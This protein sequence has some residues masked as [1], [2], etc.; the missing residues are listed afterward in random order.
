MPGLF[1]GTSL[2]RPVTCERCLKPLEACACPRNAAGEIALPADQSPRVR[3]ERRRGAWTTVITGLDP[4]ATDL[5]SLCA[6]LKRQ[7]AS[8]GS[9]KKDA[10]EIQGDHRD[11]V[12]ASLKGLGYAAKAAGG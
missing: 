4:V 3:R 9:V 8:G 7:L 12:V 6:S 10:I 11:T 2:E 1:A 5:D